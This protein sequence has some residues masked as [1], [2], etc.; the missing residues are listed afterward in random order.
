MVVSAGVL[1]G[2]A[3]GSGRRKDSLK[4]RVSLDKTRH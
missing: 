2:Q 4:I 1:L 3:L